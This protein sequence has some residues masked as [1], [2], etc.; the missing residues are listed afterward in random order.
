MYE[1]QALDAMAVKAKELGKSGVGMAMDTWTSEFSINPRLRVIETPPRQMVGEFVELAM[2]P[3]VGYLSQGL[4]AVEIKSIGCGKYALKSNG[5]VL[6]ASYGCDDPEAGL[7]IASAGLD[8][9][10]RY[11][12]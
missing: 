2:E 1:E 10:I 6:F 4:P 9:L 7:I 12:R 11:T 8:I 5:R 3:I